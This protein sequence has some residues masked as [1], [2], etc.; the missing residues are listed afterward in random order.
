M[1]RPA[2]VGYSSYAVLEDLTIAVSGDLPCWPAGGSQ[3]LEIKRVWENWGGAIRNAARRHDFPVSWLVGI[4]CVESSGNP[5]ACSPCM[6]HCCGPYAE[7]IGSSCCAYGLMQFTDQVARMY[8]STGPE[9]IS[10]GEL[11]IELGAH[12]LS[13]LAYTGQAP[14]GSSFGGRAPYGLDLVRIA[15]SYNSGSARC[16]GEGTFGLS[17]EHDYA[18][19]VVRYANT[20]LQLGIPGWAGP[21]LATMAGLG[22]AI[23]GLALAYLIWQ[24]TILRK[25]AA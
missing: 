2:C 20:A 9:L 19:H 14:D 12:H 11:A 13:D 22:L 21:S 5:R 10:D 1:E 23:G 17:G 15:S 3:E 16:T 7:R 8:G 18:M 4:M 25:R 24:G 6:S